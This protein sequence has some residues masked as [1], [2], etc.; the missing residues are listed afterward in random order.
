M[1]NNDIFQELKKA[2]RKTEESEDEFVVH[3]TQVENEDDDKDTD[4]GNYLN[5]IKTIIQES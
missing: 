5:T 1:H 3:E 4:S 2:L